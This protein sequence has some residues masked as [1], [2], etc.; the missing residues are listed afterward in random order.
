[1]NVECLV[2]MDCPNKISVRDRR[3]IKDMRPYDF[4][5]AILV[6][7]KFAD[8]TVLRKSICIKLCN[9]SWYT[10]PLLGQALV[11]HLPPF[12]REMQ[13]PVGFQSLLLEIDTKPERNGHYYRVPGYSDLEPISDDFSTWSLKRYVAMPPCEPLV[14][15][16]KDM[17]EPDLGPAI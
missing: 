13:A 14:N 11:G 16:I 5:A 3:N 15:A 10:F 8:T 7:K 2:D 12:F 4:E 9:C 1:M 6:L 17:L